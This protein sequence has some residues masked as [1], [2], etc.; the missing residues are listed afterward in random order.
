MS[1]INDMLRDLERRAETE[2]KGG[3]YDLPKAVATPREAPD[4]LRWLAGGGLLLIFLATLGYHFLPQSRIP[5][6]VP[7]PLAAAEAAPAK[8]PEPAPAA[9][10]VEPQKTGQPEPPP[11]ALA[12]SAPLKPAET[13]EPPPREEPPPA[14]KGPPP[15]EEAPEPVKQNASRDGADRAKQDARA[16][17][18]PPVRG[19]EGETA[20]AA[21]GES[22]VEPAPAK[23]KAAKA[24]ALQ[25]A[26]GGAVKRVRPEEGLFIQAK[27]AW[28][29]GRMAEAEEALRKTLTLDAGHL[30]ARLMLAT[31]L[32]NEKR[33]VEAVDI[34]GTASAGQGANT[35]LVVIRAR[36]LDGLGQT[37]SALDYLGRAVPK[38]RPAP[39][40]VEQL[41]AALLQKLGRY[42]ESAALYRR[43]VGRDQ[44]DAQSW[45]GLGI[46]LEGAGE[47]DEALAAYR[48]ALAVNSLPLPLTDYL[49][50]RVNL[51]SNGAPL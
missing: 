46:S 43:L 42:A 22:P 19:D 9:A 13:Q 15:A 11:V 51:L 1:L 32:L 20:L 47:R 28:A 5:M 48:R 37:E 49:R 18:F 26:S 39:V 14:R 35:G 7:L 41:R 27:R 30:P 12:Q 45:A 38:G 23:P 16:E 21:A 24:P 8:S 36:A 10:P 4:L 50:R 25:P 6:A 33:L 2:K 17:E 31:L 34:T 29:G 3:G 44:V 40:A